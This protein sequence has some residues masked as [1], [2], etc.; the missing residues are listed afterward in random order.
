[1]EFS[2]LDTL[3]IHREAVDHAYVL[4]ADAMKLVFTPST[5]NTWNERFKDQ[6]QKELD[7]GKD[8]TDCIIYSI[9][10]AAEEILKEHYFS[11][12]KAAVF[13]INGYDSEFHFLHE[14]GVR[15]L[16]D[17]V[18]KDLMMNVFLRSDFFDMF[19]AERIK[20]CRH[21]HSL[22]D[23]IVYAEDCYRVPDLM[24]YSSYY[25]LGKGHAEDS[26][27]EV[28]RD[29]T[30]EEYGK[31]LVDNYKKGNLPDS[32]FHVCKDGVIIEADLR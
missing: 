19:T 1:M 5:I 23:I 12:Y 21:D 26:G 4:C 30:D 3:G 31:M 22:T 29:L 11:P 10:S 24:V 6:W 7:P 14:E 2:I 25:E 15:E 16:S 9:F 8:P 13:T 32:W 17:Y 20:E 27:R 28:T 18:S